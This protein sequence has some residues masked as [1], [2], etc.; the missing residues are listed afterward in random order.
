MTLLLKILLLGILF[1]SDMLDADLYE[2]S[3]A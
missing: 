2:D 3:L 1:P